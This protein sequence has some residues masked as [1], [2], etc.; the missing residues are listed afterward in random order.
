MSLKH[1]VNDSLKRRLFQKSE[2][3]RYLYHFLIKKVLFFHF[4]N[5]FFF[6]KKLN[7]L[8][9]KL[10]LKAS[11]VQF[12]NRCIFSNRSRSIFCYFGLS[13]HSFKKLA[14]FGLLVGVRKAVW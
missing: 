14:T 12:C 4:F 10:P 1:K 6:V 5:S 8:F 13:R 7:H 2:T 11:G 9:N 3:K